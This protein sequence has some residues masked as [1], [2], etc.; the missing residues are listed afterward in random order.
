MGHGENT[1]YSGGGGFGIPKNMARK[2]L[3]EFAWDQLTRAMPELS[4]D[5]AKAFLRAPVP[6][7]RTHLPALVA[8]DN[9]AS[10]LLTTWQLGEE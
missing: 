8:D 9:E 10:R 3:P 4:P 7:G 5:E 6:A 1:P 2:A